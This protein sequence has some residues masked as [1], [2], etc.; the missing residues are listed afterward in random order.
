MQII[1]GNEEWAS[2]GIRITEGQ[3]KVRG[4]KEADQQIISTPAR[5]MLAINRLGPTGYHR[6]RKSSP[7]PVWVLSGKC[8]RR[9]VHEYLSRRGAEVLLGVHTPALSLSSVG[10]LSP[11]LEPLPCLVLLL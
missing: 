5:N 9:M 11:F 10:S 4:N 1:H 2:I 8:S 6:Y 3:G 7:V